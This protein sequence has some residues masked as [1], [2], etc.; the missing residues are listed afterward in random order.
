MVENETLERLENLS[1][2]IQQVYIPLMEKVDI[3]IQMENFVRQM[4]TSVRQAYGNVTLKVT[5]IPE[6][7]DEQQVINNPELIAKLS[8]DVVSSRLA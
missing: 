6:G 7:M 4:Q 3:K 1:A 2:T 8:K 5:E